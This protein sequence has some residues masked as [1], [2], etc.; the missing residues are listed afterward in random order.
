MAIAFSAVPVVEGRAPANP[1]AVKGNGMY[2]RTF[3]CTVPASTTVA[4]LPIGWLPPGTM[5][6]AATIDK[7]TSLGATSTLSLSTSEQV[8]VAAKND[9]VTGGVGQIIVDNKNL[10]VKSSTAAGLAVNLILAAATSP[11]SIIV[12]DVT[13]VLASVLPPEDTY[14]TQST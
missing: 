5:V 8:F 11:A 10:V 2:T 14:T 1:L 9:T 6:V 13:L 12:I 3:R 4:T 7:D